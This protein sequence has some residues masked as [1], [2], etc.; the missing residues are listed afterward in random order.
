MSGC[1]N[2]EWQFGTVIF[3]Y[4]IVGHP[5]AYLKLKIA[6]RNFVNCLKDFDK[7]PGK[8]NK[9]HSTML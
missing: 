9:L 7:H 4:Q 2:R 6:F 5:F 3:V 1:N 8:Q